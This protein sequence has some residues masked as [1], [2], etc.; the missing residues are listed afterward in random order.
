MFE[1]LKEI[2]L[3]VTIQ[4]L[5]SLVIGIMLL[6]SPAAIITI[7]AKVIAAIIIISG[8][9]FLISALTDS[10]KSALGITVS[11]LVAI[12]GIWMFVHPELI[13]SLIPIAMGVL[14]VVHG[15]KDFSLAFDTKGNKGDKWWLGILAGILNILLGIV[16]IGNA[17]GIVKI[18]VQIIGIMLIY[19]GISDMFIVHKANQSAKNPVDSSIVYEQDVDEFDDFNK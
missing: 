9:V 18:A 16:C 1:K 19:D 8:V 2:N 6:V 3:N 12:I 10:S 17:F 4:A 13:A 5:I 7:I 11:I 14:L 15:V